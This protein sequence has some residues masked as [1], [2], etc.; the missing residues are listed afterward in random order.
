V[1]ELVPVPVACAAR[2]GASAGLA[3]TTAEQAAS[4]GLARVLA[5]PRVA[6]VLVLALVLLDCAAHSTDSV[7]RPLPIAEQ[8]A[9]LVL[10]PALRRRYPVAPVSVPALP[11]RAAGAPERAEPRAPFAEPAASVHMA[12]VPR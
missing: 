3:V 4:L 5:L 6:V 7:A 9:S 8:V 1:L 11:D 2:N 10:V 12:R